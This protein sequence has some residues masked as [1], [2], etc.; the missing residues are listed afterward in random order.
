MLLL[1]AC[2]PEYE[3]VNKVHRALQLATR[4]RLHRRCEGRRQRER[5][6]L[7]ARRG[8]PHGR[9]TKAGRQDLPCTAELRGAQGEKTG[10]RQHEP[11]AR[12][13]GVRDEHCVAYYV[14]ACVRA[15]MWVAG[16]GAMH[17][18]VRVCVHVCACSGEGGGGDAR[19]HIPPPR[20]CACA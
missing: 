2:L 8:R 18:C 17:A 13:R 3:R 12:G 16:G 14:C 5:L 9:V 11:G 19:P 7:L 6:L 20:A 15:G 1:P 10:G 4:R